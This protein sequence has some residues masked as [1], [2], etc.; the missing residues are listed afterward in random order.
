MIGVEAAGRG[1]QTGKHAATLGAGEVGVL[2][3]SKSYVLQDEYG[4]IKE[5]HSIAAG[6]DYPGVGPEHAY[7]K[8]IG[9]VRYVSVRD[10][11]ALEAFDALSRYEGIIPALESA[12]ALAW[13][14]VEARQRKP[15]EVLVVN[16]SGRGDKDL[17][18]VWRYRNQSD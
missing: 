13:A 6:L 2:H 11:E 8:E 1:L 4:Q 3:G 15:Q 12:H 18:V 17:E 10:D 5:A 14:M 7:L 9:R 16:L